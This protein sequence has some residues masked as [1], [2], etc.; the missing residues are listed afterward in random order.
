MRNTL[1]EKA[2]KEYC[3][4]P[5][6]RIDPFDIPEDISHII[7]RVQH[8]IDLVDESHREDNNEFVSGSDYKKLQRFIKKWSKHIN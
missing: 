6:V 7:F 8:E 4:L 5:E 3:C 2:Y 1:F